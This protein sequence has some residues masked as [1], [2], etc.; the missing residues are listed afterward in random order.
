M[1]VTSLPLTLSRSMLDRLLLPLAM[2]VLTYKTYCK[3]ELQLTCKTFSRD[4]SKKLQ[5]FKLSEECLKQKG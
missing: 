1:V 5:S 4:I 3:M 2:A